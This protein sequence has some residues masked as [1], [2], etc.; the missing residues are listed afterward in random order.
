MN[1]N[2][3]SSRQ[4][5]TNISNAERGIAL[6][7]AGAVLVTFLVLVFTPTAMNS[8][9]LAIVRFLAAT[10]AGISGYLYSGNLTLEAKVPWSKAQIRATGGFAAFIV[11]LLLFFYGIP[12]SADLNKN[13]S[14]DVA[15]ELLAKVQRLQTIYLDSYKEL[16]P[17]FIEAGSMLPHNEMYEVRDF[18]WRRIEEVEVDL[19][20][21]ILDEDVELYLL[22][23]HSYHPEVAKRISLMIDEM[24]E[25]K[26]VFF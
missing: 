11:V 7:F 19:N 15:L 14:R 5:P 12:Q 25:Q 21:R 20:K 17:S 16:S 4:E 8:G 24:H 6:G 10:F 22:Q 9:T 13:S 18:L 23:L 2:R 3:K 26:H 1:E